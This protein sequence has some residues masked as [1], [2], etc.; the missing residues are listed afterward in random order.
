MTGS[1]TD[2]RVFLG[3]D[4]TGAT[5]QKKRAKPLPVAVLFQNGTSVSPS[6]WKLLYSSNGKR[7]QIP[8]L[9]KQELEI[10]TNIHVP[11]VDSKNPLGGMAL[12][13]DSVFGLPESVW[14]RSQA[15]S[16]DLFRLFQGAQRFSYQGKHLGRDTAEAFFLQFLTE[17]Q[18]QSWPQRLCEVHSG[19][20]S[21]FRTRPFQ[22]NIGCGTFRIWKE[23]GEASEKWFQ[24]W[25]FDSPKSLKKPLEKPW[26]FEAYPSLFWK[27][28]L[29]S[30]SRDPENLI[31]FLK[32][33][34]PQ[35]L[36]DLSKDFSLLR[37]DPDLCDSVV[38]A[39]SAWQLQEQ[40]KLWN[41]PNSVPQLQQEGW[42]LGLEI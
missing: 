3:V 20:N 31:L 26:I 14:P 22:R 25:G 35:K 4:Q 10:F 41:L 27:K 6:A 24:I 11:K 18:K 16:E 23:L 39:L 19:A 28:I 17:K 8:R 13:L 21:I 40:Q 9:T 30:R 15:G 32:A 33:Q 34:N 29:G 1:R 38:L 12:I 2:F 42:I 37:S 5:D 36:Q 7:L